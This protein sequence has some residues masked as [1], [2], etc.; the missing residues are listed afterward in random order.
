L[1]ISIGIINWNTKGLLFNLLEQLRYDD[2]KYRREIIVV[3][4]ASRD[5]SPQ[6]VKEKFPE[7]K[8]IQNSKNLGFTKACNQIIEEME[9]DYLLLLNTDL[10]I[11]RGGIDKLVDFME[12]NKDAALCGPK[13]VYPDGTLQAS[14]RSF[15]NL[16][17]V[18]WE[19]TGLY[20]LFPKS[21]VFGRYFLTF[22]DHAETREVDFV[23]GAAYLM[24]KSAIDDVGIFDEDYFLYVQDA[25]WCY[26]AHKKGWKVYY[27]PE[28]T[29]VHMEGQ[30]VK[31][32]GE[33]KN[34]LSNYERLIFFKKHYGESQAKMLY[35]LTL[36]FNELKRGFKSLL[37]KNSAQPRGRWLKYYRKAGKKLL[38][39][40]SCNI[41]PE[42]LIHSGKP[43][44]P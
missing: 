18:L 41:D 16:T 36:F 15:H 5:G 22:W 21:E 39:G 11:Q 29:F 1:L 2:T 9:G 6:L 13:L 27:C 19:L 43:G 24:R 12:K 14:V 28:V 40:R 33:I 17:T 26:R 20:K 34:F 44:F 10:Q 4:N 7:V 25:D 42:S 3:D 38:W 32:L 30:T 35:V 23:S 37:Y 31:K 8:L